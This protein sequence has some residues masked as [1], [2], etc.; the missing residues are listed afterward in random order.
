MARLRL[1][2]IAL[3]ACRAEA[4]PGSGVHVPASWRALPELAAAV[5]SASHASAAE[6]WGDPAMGCY[7]AWLAA[8]GETGDADAVLAEVQRDVPKI[9]LTDIVKPQGAGK[10]A[11]SFERAP[12]RGRVRATLATGGSITALACFW[13]EREPSA[14]AL[15]CTG[16]LGSVP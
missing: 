2:V 4:A 12:Y 1:I 7:A 8:K 9:A 16:V 13:N 6:A 3:A 5:S 11:L 15:A 10:L 14:C